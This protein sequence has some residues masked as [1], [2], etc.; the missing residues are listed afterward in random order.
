MPLYATLCCVCGKKVKRYRITENPTC[1][2]R[3]KLRHWRESQLQLRMFRDDDG[4][5]FVRA[6][7]TPDRHDPHVEE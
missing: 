4:L 5:V 7:T 2:A 6:G 1:S 3:C